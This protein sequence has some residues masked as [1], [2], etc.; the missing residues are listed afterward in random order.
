MEI[1]IIMIRME[2]IEEIIRT[3]LREM[4]KMRIEYLFD[5]GCESVNKF[6]FIAVQGEREN[7]VVQLSIVEKNIGG[8]GLGRLP[9]LVQLV[10]TVVN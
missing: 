8:L 1:A 4:R 2:K 10:E 9:G 5:L 3:D 6:T 7:I